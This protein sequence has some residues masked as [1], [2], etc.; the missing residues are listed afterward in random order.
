MNIPVYS[1]AGEKL[2]EF[3][4]D[5]AALGGRV[6]RDVLRQAV[7][8]YEANK[9]VG[10]AKTKTRGDKSHSDAKLYRQKHTGRA[11]AGSRNSPTRVGGG[12]A[13]GPVPRDYSQKLNK[14]MRRLAVRSAVLAKMRDDEVKI[15]EKL[16]LSGPKTREM[17]R[18]LRGLG[19]ERS[20]LLV[21]PQ[22]D[23]QIWLATRNIEGSAVMSVEELNAYDL[24]RARQVVFTQAAIE[25]LLALAAARNSKDDGAEPADTG[26][27]K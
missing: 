5:E 14:K 25:K 2:G 17:A 19:I 15:V 6:N 4:V 12:V 18:V 11:R 26:E 3:D 22:K 1:A 9:R 23:D 10:T 20:F 8:A 13:H 7:L 16:E 27:D 21:L 24:L